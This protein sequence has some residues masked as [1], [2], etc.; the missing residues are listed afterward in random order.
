MKYY[1]LQEE[2]FKEQDYQLITIRE[3]DMP[4]IKEWRNEQMK[5]LRQDRSLSDE[6]QRNYYKQIVLPSIQE[7]RPRI[8]LFTYLFQGT[9]IGYGGLTNI[10]WGSR[11]AEV[12]YLLRSDRSNEAERIQYI[13]DFTNYLSILKRIAFEQLHLNRLFTETF[14]IRPLHITILEQ[15]GFILEGK[16]RQHVSIEGEYVDSIIHGCLKGD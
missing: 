2:T 9:V 12:S 6:D 7:E 1:Q 3:Q 16:M 11:R 10:D 4:L 14:N 13:D 8:M 5:V 15:N